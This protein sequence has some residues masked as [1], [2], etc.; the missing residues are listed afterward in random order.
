V[1]VPE[2]TSHGVHSVLPTPAAYAPEG[3]NVHA[4]VADGSSGWNCPAMQLEQMESELWYWPAG[5][6][7]KEMSTWAKPDGSPSPALTPTML[8]P[9]LA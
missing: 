3:H 5:H 6:P 8:S 2:K 4:A 1:N 7:V 9:V